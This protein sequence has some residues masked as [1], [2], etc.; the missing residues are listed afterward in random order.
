MA[1]IK[2]FTG[3]INFR[4]IASVRVISTSQEIEQGGFIGRAVVGGALLGGLGAVIG[5]ATRK[6]SSKA[7][8]TFEA[9]LKNG[10]VVQGVASGKEIA[11][12]TQYIAD[13]QEPTSYGRLIAFAL[14]VAFVYFTTHA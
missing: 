7:R 9:T 2:T 6:T 4:D 11:A 14:F 13:G 10:Q 1:S 5:A 12:L 8:H 3:R